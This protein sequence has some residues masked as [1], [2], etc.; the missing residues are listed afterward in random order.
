METIDVITKILGLILSIA[1]IAIPLVFLILGHR[2]KK[3]HK[4]AEQV[5]AYYYLQEVAIQKISDLTKQPAKTIKEDLRKQ[6]CD[7][8]DN[9]KSIRP[10]MTA[11]M[12][13]KYL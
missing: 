3:R 1:G 12:A 5:I 10:T 13:E 11:K 7:Y 2:D 8:A 9:K 4:L 6:A